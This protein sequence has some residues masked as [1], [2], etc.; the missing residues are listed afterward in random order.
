MRFCRAAW[1]THERLGNL[2]RAVHRDE[3][4]AL[5]KLLAAI[6][7][8]LVSFFARRIAPSVSEDLAQVA[9]MRIVRAI[10]RIDPERADRY[11]MTVAHNLLRTEF[12]RR[13]R[14]ARRELPLDLASDI[15][16]PI[17][18][19]VE[20]EQEELTR[21][22]HRVSLDTLPPS[23]REIVLSLLRGLTPAEIAEQEH[24]NPITIRTRLMRARA[25]L[26]RELWPYLV[27]EDGADSRAARSGK[28]L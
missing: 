23:L 24:L 14:D 21:A 27:V 11:V 1:P 8:A 6:R 26:R 3:P 5:D 18:L 19:H 15:E 2:V 25:L 7:P 9:L 16:A 4:R 17:M 10:D 20:V 22:I 12:R 28:E 13:A